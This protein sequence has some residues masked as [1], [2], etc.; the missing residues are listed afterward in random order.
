MVHGEMIYRL[1]LSVQQG[2][3]SLENPYE[4][5][6]GQV[7]LDYPP[8]VGILSEYMSEIF[9]LIL[10]N[11]A[12]NISVVTEPLSGSTANSG[13]PTGCHGSIYRNKSDITLMPVD[14]P[15]QDYSKVDPIQAVHEGP[16]N[17]LSIY[18]VEEKNDTVYTDLFEESLKSFDTIIWSVSVSS[19][20]AFAGLL[21]VRK[22]I[23]REKSNG[24]SPLLE[25]FSHLIGQASTDF[26]DR[27]G[28]VISTVMTI[29][30]FLIL[31]FYLN[32][33][34]TDLVVV[35]KPP[36]I[37]NYRD[38][39]KKNSTVGFLA[40][41]TDVSHFQ[42]AEK[43]SIQEEFW[44]QYLTTHFL[45]DFSAED[46]TTLQ[47]FGVKMM[48]KKAVFVVSSI[49]GQIVLETCCKAKE[50]RKEIPMLHKTYGWLSS[51]PDGKQHQ[52][53]I[54]IRQGLNTDLIKKGKK[55]VRGLF[56][57]HIFLTGLWKSIAK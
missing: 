32:L 11:A 31:A 17:I 46:Q 55:K 29:A 35:D 5:R 3:L 25:M 15:I 54:I 7:H 26:N 34:S 4:W 45:I 38:I 24:Y 37:N 6:N 14:Y 16:L 43:G 52:T 33:M 1:C 44:K 51:D 36:T 39:M 41:F 27:P 47:N 50:S 48:F 56:E 28:R 19:F 57:G 13:S 10:G 22:V 21:V 49:F 9:P 30:F 20:L 8:L 23:L 12:P 53:G 40:A 18:K 42:N 2:F